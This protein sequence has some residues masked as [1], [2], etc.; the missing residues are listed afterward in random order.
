MEARDLAA[1]EAAGLY[2]PAAPNAA[3]RLELLEWLLAQRLTVGSNAQS[4]HPREAVRQH[5]TAEELPELADDEGRQPD[6]VR[7][8]RT[9]TSC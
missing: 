5:A 4:A 9:A 6:A 1:L 7:D 2:D 3:E 8:R